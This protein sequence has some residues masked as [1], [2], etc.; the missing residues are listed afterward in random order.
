[1]H[2]LFVS[3]IRILTILPIGGKDTKNFS[4]TVYF[5]P[6]VGFILGSII[7]TAYKVLYHIHLPS[8]L[9]TIVILSLSFYLT[10]FIHID[11]IGDTADAFGGGR[12]KDKI[13]S[14]FKDS[15]MGT[16]GV[17][18][19]VMTILIK[20]HCYHLAITNNVILVFI[21]YSLILGRTIQAAYLHLLPSAT[22]QSLTASFSDVPTVAKIGTIGLCTLLLTP[23]FYLLPLSK[24]IATLTLLIFIHSIFIT[25]CIQKIGGI[26]GDCVGTAN[27][28]T[29]MSILLLTCN[30]IS[31][32][33]REVVKFLESI[34]T[35]N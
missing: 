4:Y 15:R 2:S 8:E 3:A 1:M 24:A 31:P 7:I 14:I 32:Q 29:E 13:L 25:K 22:P 34:T 12:S 18:A 16:F 21:P 19:L 11:G 20:Y 6:F 9:L 10:G 33:T 17:V 27:E 23:L 28:L 30:V 26:T 35:I 5:F